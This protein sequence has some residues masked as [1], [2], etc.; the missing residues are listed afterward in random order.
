MLMLMQEVDLNQNSN[1]K[2][3]FY[4]ENTVINFVIFYWS[5]FMSF[6]TNETA[7]SFPTTNHRLQD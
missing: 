6:S 7:D 3:L 5:A 1:L 2:I 4:S